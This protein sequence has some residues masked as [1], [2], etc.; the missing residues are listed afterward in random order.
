VRA[1]AVAYRHA[2][3]G[4]RDRLDRTDARP[5]SLANAGRRKFLM[6]IIAGPF[7][8]KTASKFRFRAI[9]HA[10]FSNRN[11]FALLFLSILYVLYLSKA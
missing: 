5:N 8:P 3:G 2:S 9:N 7:I 6:L 11:G 10:K 4:K 1:V